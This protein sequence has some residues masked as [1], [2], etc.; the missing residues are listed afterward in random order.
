MELLVFFDEKADIL[1]HLE[2][3]VHPLSLLHLEVR[4]LLQFDCLLRAITKPM[5]EVGAH[6]DIAKLI[7]DFAQDIVNLKLLLILF[8]QPTLSQRLVG[9]LSRKHVIVFLAKY[10]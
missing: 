8:D 7:L 9:E 6:R 3:L 1:N 10:P 4:H 5:M 2:L